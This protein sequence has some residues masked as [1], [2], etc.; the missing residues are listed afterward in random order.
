MWTSLMGFWIYGTGEKGDFIVSWG[1]DVGIPRRRRII[2]YGID[3]GND[4]ST[5]WFAG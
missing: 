1:I 3:D 2:V 4:S 5:Q